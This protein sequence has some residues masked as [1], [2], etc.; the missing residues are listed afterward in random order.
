HS[1]GFDGRGLLR[2]PLHQLHG[3]R[4]LTIFNTFQLKRTARLSLAHS[5]STSTSTKMVDHGIGLS[6]GDT[7]FLPDRPPDGKATLVARNAA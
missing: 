5:T 4:A 1:G 6:G 7:T 2:P 3:E